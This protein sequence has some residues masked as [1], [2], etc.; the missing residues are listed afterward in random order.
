MN[1][2]KTQS[3]ESPN[4]G[5]CLQRCAQMHRG[6]SGLKPARTARPMACSARARTSFGTFFRVLDSTGWDRPREDSLDAR[7]G[8]S[9]DDLELEFTLGSG[10]CF[11]DRFGAKYL[12]LIH[13]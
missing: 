6:D 11:E 9:S 10:Y 7:G 4:G 13:I 3:I 1:R 2:G 8:Y 5:M 12:S